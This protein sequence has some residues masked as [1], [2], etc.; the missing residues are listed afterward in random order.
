MKLKKIA[1]ILILNLILGTSLWNLVVSCIITRRLG[2]VLSFKFGIVYL[3]DTARNVIKSLFYD[4]I[5]IS[6]SIARELRMFKQGG[7]IR[8]NPTNGI[9]IKSSLAQ[10]ASVVKIFSRTPAG[11]TVF[12]PGFQHE[13]SET[14]ESNF[15]NCVQATGRP[16]KNSESLVIKALGYKQDRM[17]LQ[18]NIVQHKSNVELNYN[19]GLLRNCGL[20]S[21][22]NQELV[23]TIILG[24]RLVNNKT[25]IYETPGGGK[26][27]HKHELGCFPKG[28]LTLE[29]NNACDAFDYAYLKR[30]EL[31]ASWLDALPRSDVETVKNSL[32]SFN[33]ILNFHDP[34]Q[35]LKIQ[36]NGVFLL[37]RFQDYPHYL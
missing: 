19:S 8:F 1:E 23:H 5:N 30:Q 20:T 4:E 6:I 7:R 13:T 36:D 3:A 14:G 37:E 32:N 25:I 33:S 29:N 31:I 9:I 22:K 12:H 34:V 28:I 21:V 15:V 27:I 11:N 2:K 26:I 35:V 16:V 24:N 18:Y 10:P 17:F